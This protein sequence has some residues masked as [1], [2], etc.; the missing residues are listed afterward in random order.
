MTAQDFNEKYKE[1]L[2]EG[3]YG[4]IISVT[5]VVE[6]LDIIFDEVLTKIPGFK[7]Q[8]I[9]TKFGEARLYTSIKS[10][11]FTVMV[12]QKINKLLKENSK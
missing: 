2:E 12:E 10:Y 11:D 7:Y 8:Q 5:S 6:F 4:L 3:F 9:K 1:Y